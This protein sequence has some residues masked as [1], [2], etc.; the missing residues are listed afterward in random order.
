MKKASNAATA[1][2]HIE[3]V[4]LAIIGIGC[5]FPQARNLPEYWANLREGVDAI[6]EVP[7]EYWQPQDYFD[8]DP[9]KPDH[10][11]ST[12]GAFLPKID[13]N[14]LEF[15]VT[16]NALE[17]TDTAQL[18]GLVAAQ[19]A[20]NDAG[21][22]KERE[23]DRRRV[24]VILGVTGTLELVIPLGARLGHPLWRRALQEAGVEA[25]VAADVIERIQHGYV[26]WQENSF[27]GLLGNVVAGRIAN[28]FD[29]GG[30]NC[31]VDAAC[32]SSL[33][34]VHLAGL[35]LA[36]GRADMVVT[37]GVDTFNHIFMYMCFSKTPALSPSGHARPFDQQADGTTLGEGIGMIVLKRLADAQRAGDRIYAVIKSIG[38]SSDGKGQAIY[39]P[40]AKGQVRAYQEAYQQAGITPD[41][42]ELLEAHG[43]GTKVGDLT[44]LES[45][46]AMYGEFRKNGAW[47]A[48]GSVKSQIGHTKAAAGVA[49]LIKAALALHHKVLPPTIK[50][51]T[52]LPE[53]T[54]GKTPFYLNTQ[55]RPWLPSP[56]HPR[57]AAVSAFGFG[58]SNF[59]CV[60]EEA[61]P[62]KPAIDWTG[63][64]Q[65]LAFAAETPAQLQTTLTE[66]ETTPDWTQLRSA[67]AKLRQNF[68]GRKPCRLLLVVEKDSSD[69]VKM[70]KNA[71]K[72][73]QSQPQKAAWNTPDG[74]YYGSGAAVGTLGVIFP[75]QGSQYVG[76][77]RDFACQFPQFQQVLAAADRVF[78][79]NQNGNGNGAQRL[80]DLIYPPPTFN[81]ADQQHNAAV[82]QSTP[83]AQPAIGAVSLGLLKVLEHFG[84][85][86]Q[87]VA[88]HSYGEL[89]ALCAAGVLEPETFFALSKLR[90]QLMGQKQGDKGSMLAV[91]AT[92]ETVSEILKAEQLELV[93]ANKNSPQQ[94][95]L[96]GAT[97]EIERGRE[98]FE[99][100]QFRCKQLAVAAAFHSRFV[101]DASGAFRQALQT[102]ALQPPQLPVF[103]DSTGELYPAEIDHIRQ[104][105]ADQLTNPVE[106][107]RIIENM[108]ASGV[109]TFVEVGPS[110]QMSGL[111]KA[112][113][114]GKSVEVLS[115]DASTGSRSGETD[116]ARA[117]AQLVASGHPAQLALW[118]AAAPLPEE[119][120]V[121][122]KRGMTVTL[123]GANYMAPRPTK[124][125]RAPQK[126]APV[127]LAE[128]PAVL[129]AQPSIPLLGGDRGG[130]PQ[131]GETP[132]GQ[133]TPNPSQEGNP[134]R[135]SDRNLTN[136]LRMT[137]ENLRALQQFQEQTANLHRQF[138]EGQNAARQTFDRLLEQQ[139]QLLQQAASSSA[140]VAPPAFSKAMPAAAAIAAQPPAAP[141]AVIVP[142]AAEEPRRLPKQP[143]PPLPEAQSS[144]QQQVQQVLLEVVSEKTGY[145]AEMLALE[146]G[147]DADLGIDS[148][149]R[150]EILSALQ[151][152][153]PGAPA[154]R[155]EQIGTLQ[156]L[157]QIVALLS[158][159]GGPKPASV[160]VPAT[161]FPSSEG[162]GVGLPSSAAT[163]VSSPPHKDVR[164]IETILLEVV[165]EKTGYPAEMLALEMGLDAD[166]G[167]DSIKRVE[168]L[169]ALQ[170]RLPGAPAIRSEQI[171]TLQ[172]LG[173]IVALLSTNGGTKPVNVTT[174]V[175]KIPSGEG[176]GVGLWVSPPLVGG[177]GGGAG[178][179]V[180]S[181]LLEVVAEKTG[182]PAEML[183]LGMGLDA[184]LG[185]DSIKRVEILSA[186][187]ERLPGA[188]VIRSEQLGQIRTLQ[189]IVELLG[190]PSPEKTAPPRPAPAAPTGSHSPD[191]L[192]AIEMPLERSLI[193]P[194][195]L[196]EPDR[197]EKIVLSPGVMIW[198]A[199]DTTPLT[200]AL[201]A[202]LRAQGF[203]P[204]RIAWHESNQLA[205]PDTL[206]GLVILAPSA[207]AITET[208]L[209]DAF[210]LAQ[211][212]GPGLRNAGRQGQAVFVTVSRLDG[213]FGF[214][215]LDPQSNPLAGGL[216]GLA[217]TVGREWPEIQSKALDVARNY[218]D[219]QAAA[220][221]LA[222]MFR[223][224]PVEV[225]IAPE[226]RI[227]LQLQPAAF[228]HL[229]V[230]PLFDRQD[231]IL[232]TGGARGVTAECAL[233]L[234]QAYRPTLVLLG[235]SPA[236]TPEPEWLAGLT[237]EA[238]LKKAIIAQAARPLTPKTVEQQYQAIL[239]N[240]EI[241]RQLARLE[242]A[243]ARVAYY[244]VD[245][246]ERDAVQAVVND[247]QARFGQI[248][249]L[250]HG[251]GVL[252]DRRIEDKTTEQ[253]QQVYSTKV[254][255]LVSLLDVLAA[256][257]LK[258]IA[259]FSSTTARLGRVGQADYAMANEVLNK[260]AQQQARLR[261]SCRVVAF[262]WGPWDGGMVT[263]ALKKM[264]AEEGV[265]VIPLSAGADYFIRELSTPAPDF[266]AVE[267]V[268]LG[269]AA[270]ARPQ[271]TA[272]R[273]IT[274]VSKLTVA[275][276][277]QIEIEQHPFL[278]SHVINGQAVLP[279]AMIMEWMAHG[280]LHGNPGLHFHGLNHLQ[281]L[282]GVIFPPARA[283]P[284]RMLTGKPRKEG[285]LYL[286]PVELHGGGEADAPSMLHAR[287]ECVLS[288]QFPQAQP[289][290]QRASFAAYPYRNGE[291]YRKYLFHGPHFH[292]LEQVEGCSA[293]GIMA[294]VK[295]A[296]LPALW[297]KQPLRSYWLTD[298]LIIDSSFQ[299]LIVWSFEQYQAGSL[300]TA[301]GRYRQFQA[302]FPTSGGRIVAQ[303]TKSDHRRALANIE[304]L[305]AH[306]ALVACIE[307]YECVIDAS[308]NEAFRRNTL[309]PLPLREAA[310]SP[311]VEGPAA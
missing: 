301:V 87:T 290:I 201:E 74:V 182:Y 141:V 20:L 19:E 67:A 138:L 295:T 180:A 113:L 78:Q 244:A 311:V 194:V 277:R 32:A 121:T 69:V 115:L 304:F 22:P 153:L 136:L 210:R 120:A 169:S 257:P 38:S 254:A 2:N 267:V 56:D 110:A 208:F 177:A 114:E 293:Q 48:L 159:N 171:G 58:G 207:E 272:A 214:G 91:Q 297:I 264:F 116:L 24:S 166:L 51:E 160:T 101:A 238:A 85:H 198:V 233:A 252:A 298:P 274:P 285:N 112:I 216:A 117:L 100:R 13:F 228:S 176:P 139:Q 108:H 181:V 62:D 65:I 60:L 191:S 11:Y 41:T 190:Q 68:D 42:I 271:T 149:K 6:T 192:P 175:P 16:P 229:A 212:A 103:A 255:G 307:D 170:D 239:T 1:A 151:D 104:I 124:P 261:P 27:P 249:G 96:S 80:T 59:H 37:G 148:I 45:L 134:Y 308:L 46:T 276:E 21:Y 289:A 296:P 61:A 165:S 66:F 9:K 30:T 186:L 52:P 72:M 241:H 152:R 187:Q 77:L 135:C 291:I 47:C 29:L 275:F 75:G 89:V 273:P 253:F 268:V 225:G 193:R 53:L 97:A 240:R 63:K 8:R 36:R 73:L 173:Q 232:V 262:N 95:V 98:I 3:P 154:I 64:T 40:S 128:K 246:R 200:A 265:G 218:N 94:T 71:R 269:K 189:N 90:G 119:T 203:Q 145:P 248:T 282:K 109:R 286:V 15:G 133:P 178:K 168:I 55:K 7:P 86:A 122:K 111:I 219:A 43:T 294:K 223:A 278:N 204:Q 305:D 70:I 39:A 209:T 250:V 150:V 300:P 172:T 76:M 263:P 99:N 284:L 147:L 49:G 259:L 196:A 309:S 205:A 92:V 163:G 162:P 17:A 125:P 222:E 179:G 156:T 79:Q 131:C 243:G 266:A 310:G 299:L 12:S 302:K 146:M 132:P 35:E 217:K 105:L 231:V 140:F 206:G 14:P 82:L 106:F 256:N 88:G 234:A 235:R 129:T 118:D 25:P 288:A 227:E 164:Q 221:I 93:I 23:F 28:R 10:T 4:P 143:E 251:A 107:I 174:P 195:K 292:G 102:T 157:G 202:G 283:Y 123:S 44:E 197:R 31:V 57:R 242:A 211:I 247:V 183:D 230:T 130:L 236:P 287:A 84:V 224:G 127:S 50:V 81:D 5:I 279:A 226:G 188:P 155:S 33:G 258:A 199:D 144:H 18:L 137:Q 215:A 184:D 280:A 54:S 237:Q 303:I 126:A 167:I 34:A 213:A 26:D 306:G 220:A 83:I 270:A 158:T 142:P 185:I 260:L 245:V 281:I 161:G